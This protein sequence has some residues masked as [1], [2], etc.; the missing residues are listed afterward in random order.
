MGFSFGTPEKVVF[1][2]ERC[3]D[4]LQTDAYING[5]F[6]KEKLKLNK[7]N[8]WFSTISV[9]VISA[10]YNAN[11]SAFP[12]LSLFFIEPFTRK[13]LWNSLTHARLGLTSK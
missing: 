9:I 5:K 11:D 12:L 6:V 10:Y 2:K 13:V 1:D 3:G 4:L 7:Y 8:S